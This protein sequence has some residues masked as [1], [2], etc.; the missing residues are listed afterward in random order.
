MAIQEIDGTVQMP[1]LSRDMNQFTDQSKARHKS[2][3]K[4]RVTLTRPIPPKDP[5]H[6]SP[7]EEAFNPSRLPPK[8]RKII[9][10]K[11]AEPSPSD[12][13]NRLTSSD[14]VNMK[15]VSAFA[16]TVQ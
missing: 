16:Y 1:H 7:N 14:Q 15:K 3:P 6:M 10:T 9:A 4:S 8:Y 13:K 5:R 12:L 11:T 2:R